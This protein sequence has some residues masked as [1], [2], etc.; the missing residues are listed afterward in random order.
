MYLDATKSNQYIQSFFLE[1][2]VL[3]Q[4]RDAKDLYNDLRTYYYET[5][6]PYR[7]NIPLS[8]FKDEF[9]M[10]QMKLHHLVSNVS[11][12][13]IYP[14]LMFDIEQAYIL[15]L[16]ED[17]EYLRVDNVVIDKANFKESISNHYD[18]TF[19]LNKFLYKDSLGRL[20]ISENIHVRRLRGLYDYIDI[21]LN[22][23]QKELRLRMSQIRR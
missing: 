1:A 23:N 20:C 9:F 18:V 11:L 4:K 21:H 5:Y 15:R 10:T 7:H 19:S 16:I 6:S 12:R 17:E 2:G 3:V 22:D 14:A 13:D 8:V